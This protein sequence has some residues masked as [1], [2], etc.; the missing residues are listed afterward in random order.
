VNRG[1]AII[2][3]A[4]LIAAALA[5]AVTLPALI[6]SGQD[7]PPAALSIAAGSKRIVVRAPALPTPRVVA[8]REPSNLV[9]LAPVTLAPPQSSGPSLVSAPLSGST[10]GTTG[11]G[12]RNALQTKALKRA[13]PSKRVPPPPPAVVPPPPPL[14][15]PPPPLAPESTAKGHGHQ[16]K[17]TKGKDEEKAKSHGQGHAQKQKDHGHGHG[18]GGGQTQHGH[19]HEGN[20]DHGKGKGNDDGDKGHGPKR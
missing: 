5:A 1:L 8:R 15:P 3:L 19:G 2:G 13:K 20:K 16:Q 14:S 18:Q 10:A 17:Q 6:V 12:S 9:R 4:A 11:S 7:A